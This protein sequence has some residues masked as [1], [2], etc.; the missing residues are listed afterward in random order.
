MTSAAL[1]AAQAMVRQLEKDLESARRTWAI[2]SE[3][4][5]DNEAERAGLR[6]AIAHTHA[7]HSFTDIQM[8]CAVS[9]LMAL[10][11]ITDPRG[12]DRIS[13]DA[14]RGVIGPIQGEMANNALT[15]YVGLEFEIGGEMAAGEHQR[16]KQK[17]PE[18]ITGIGTLLKSDEVKRI[19]AL[20]NEALAHA[21]SFVSIEPTFEDIRIVYR[22]ATQLISLASYAV[23]GLSTDEVDRDRIARMRAREF[24]DAFVQGI[25]MM[26][27]KGLA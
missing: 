22:Q 16:V 25:S 11:R 27:A 2:F 24:W 18:L 8:T 3:S 17:L 5:G 20:R 19:R 6:L 12:Q 21:L 10:A 14:L 4:N 1:L 26:K 23:S 9:T 15:W 7:G 13:L